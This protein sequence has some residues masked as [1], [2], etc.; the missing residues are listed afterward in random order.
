MSDRTTAEWLTAARAWLRKIGEDHK[1][2]GLPD[3]GRALIGASRRVKSANDAAAAL[4]SI[5]WW[6]STQVAEALDDIDSEVSDG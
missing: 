4:A 5:C 6:D 1:T 3:E 2:D